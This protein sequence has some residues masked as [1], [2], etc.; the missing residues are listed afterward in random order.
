MTVHA[1][2]EWE[3]IAEESLDSVLEPDD[4]DAEE[5]NLLAGDASITWRGDGK[6]FATVH[7]SAGKFVSAS[8]LG[9]QQ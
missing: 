6:Y 9:S 8:C 2:Q 3:V 7:G 4:A 1:A 5:A